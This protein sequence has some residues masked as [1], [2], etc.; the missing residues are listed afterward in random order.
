MLA[1]ERLA[2]VLGEIFMYSSNVP[3]STVSKTRF[4]LRVLCHREITAGIVRLTGSR[5]HVRWANKDTAKP[6]DLDLAIENGSTN[7]EFW[8]FR[9][10]STGQFLQST[11]EASTY[12]GLV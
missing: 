11:K 5:S 12:T 9:G 3:P 6:F 7:L 2:Y 1:I 10:L 8:V 4:C